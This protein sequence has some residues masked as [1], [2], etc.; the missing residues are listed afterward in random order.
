MENSIEY[1]KNKEKENK[2]KISCKNRNYKSNSKEQRS[3][4][5]HP[6]KKGYKTENPIK[7][8]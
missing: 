7:N 3:K 6:I 2:R 4:I 1:F 8:C 5:N